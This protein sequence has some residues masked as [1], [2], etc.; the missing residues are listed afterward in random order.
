MAVKFWMAI[1]ERVVEAEIQP[2]ELLAEDFHER[3]LAPLLA[4]LRDSL[5]DMRTKA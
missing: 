2:E 4:A 3:V 5:D 1:D